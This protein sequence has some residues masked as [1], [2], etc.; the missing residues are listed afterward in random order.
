V[1]GDYEMEVAKLMPAFHLGP[2]EL[3]DKDYEVL[4]AHLTQWVRDNRKHFRSIPQTVREYVKNVN[5]KAT[6]RTDLFNVWEAHIAAVRAMNLNDYEVKKKF[7]GKTMTYGHGGF[8]W[9]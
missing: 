1:D 3:G 5:G 2:E 9:L 8:Q 7:A 4:L 6:T